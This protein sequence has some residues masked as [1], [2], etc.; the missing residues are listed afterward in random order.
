MEVD[1]LVICCTAKMASCCE[2]FSSKNEVA[3]EN[4][5]VEIVSFPFNSLV[6]FYR[7]VTVYQRVI[8]AIQWLSG[9]EKRSELGVSSYG[10]F[11]KYR[12]P[13]II[14]FNG[15]FHYKPTILDTPF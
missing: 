6:I 11:L 13:Q 12:Y 10:G 1:P 2:V 15:I 8:L 9:S 14:H 5:P 4:G 7:Y 3:I